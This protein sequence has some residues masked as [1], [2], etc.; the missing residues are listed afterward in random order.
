MWDF[1]I[2]REVRAHVIDRS[3]LRMWCKQLLKVQVGVLAFMGGQYP[4]KS[5]PFVNF[6]LEYNFVVVFSIMNMEKVTSHL[7]GTELENWVI[8]VKWVLHFYVDSHLRNNWV[9]MFQFF[10][11]WEFFNTVKYVCQIIW[12]PLFVQNITI[13]PFIFLCIGRLGR[14]LICYL[15]S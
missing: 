11:C 2:L 1:C 15:G 4:S 3:R 9:F 7:R 6:S 5:P 10:C 8:F 13:Y 14:G 12:H